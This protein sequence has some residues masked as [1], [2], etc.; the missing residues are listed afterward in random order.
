VGGG[1]LALCLACLAVF[2]AESGWGDL[3]T[4]GAADVGKLAA[5][6][7]SCRKEVYVKWG[8]L[9]D[10]WMPEGEFEVRPNAVVL[11][12]EAGDHNTLVN[13]GRGDRPSWEQ[14]SLSL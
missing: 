3:A 14:R 9:P 5:A 8:R 6:Q 13:I 4:A 7:W 2:A 10:D 12:F 11:H 1:L